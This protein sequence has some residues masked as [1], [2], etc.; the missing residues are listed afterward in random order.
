MASLNGYSKDL[1][2][3]LIF[4]RLLIIAKDISAQQD[5]SGS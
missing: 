3:K 2:Q 4:L 1:W 5:Y